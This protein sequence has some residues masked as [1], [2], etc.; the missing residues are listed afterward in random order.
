MSPVATSIVWGIVLIMLAACKNDLDRV[1]A[2]EVS[3][4]GPDKVTFNAVYLFTDSGRIQ[5]RLA[6]GRIEE[7]MHREDRRTELGDGLELTFFDRAGAPGSVLSARR[8][9]I[10]PDAERM[11]VRENVVFVNRKGERLETEHLIWSQDSDRVYTDKPVRIARDRDVIHGIGLE[12]NE[13]F[14]KYTIRQITG[15]LYVDDGDTLAA[16]AQAQ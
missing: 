11:I 2:V 9:T 8:G 4:S 14:S 13:D 5:N 12:A 16:D 1:A 10:L 6:A 15:T 7:F 3:D